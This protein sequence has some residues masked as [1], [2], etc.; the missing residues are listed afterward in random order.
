MKKLILS[1]SVIASLFV[2]FNVCKAADPRFAVYTGG[3]R[4]G[5]YLNIPGPRYAGGAVR[6]I[7][8]TSFV[9]TADVGCE[10]DVVLAEFPSWW[11][12]RNFSWMLPVEYTNISIKPTL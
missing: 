7:N 12:A 1:L 11:Q 6:P 10:H 2:A 5:L 9:V 8:R 4:F 3:P